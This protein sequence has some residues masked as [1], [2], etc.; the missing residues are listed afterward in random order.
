MPRAHLP[1]I[2]LIALLVLGGTALAQQPARQ[3]GRGQFPVMV[4]GSLSPQLAPLE[5]PQ[6]R[7]RVGQVLQDAQK[8]IDSVLTTAQRDALSKQIGP[9][10]QLFDPR[11]ARNGRRL[12]SAPVVA[13]V[14]PRS[15]TPVNIERLRDLVEQLGLSDSQK[16]QIETL[17]KESVEKLQSAPGESDSIV[18]DLRQR[19]AQI[20]SPSQ[21]D[22][23]RQL[24]SRAPADAMPAAPDGMMGGATMMREQNRVSAADAVRMPDA[25][26]MQVPPEMV[27]E[28]PLL[29]LNLPAPAFS[30]K[31]IDGQPV[32]LSAMKGKLVLVVFGSYSSP[33]FRQ[34]AAGL[35]T[36]KKEFGTRVSML[37]IYTREMYP[38]GEWDP[39]RNQDQAISL[40]QPA[41][42]EARIEAAKQARKALQLTVPI[43][44]DS[45]DDV[46]SSAYG[47]ATNAA[48]LIG[49]DGNVLA[50]QRWFEPYAMRRAIDEALRTADPK[51]SSASPTAGK[52]NY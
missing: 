13:P 26:P 46:T 47:A 52:S 32:E 40:D 14:D 51:P 22:Q 28:I 24:A 33:S 50:R 15:A 3:G 37:L 7:Q 48:Y 25:P 5:P 17:F 42:I 19:L 20:L 41:N 2:A 36:L 35:E 10:P 39:Q 4:L 6:R 44:V 43:A 16:P 29:E 45:F 30:L 11:G 38:K 1:T 9:L 27:P 49:R 23:L 18:L 8:D 12:A 21:V 31:R 34:R